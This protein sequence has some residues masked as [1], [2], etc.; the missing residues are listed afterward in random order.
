MSELMLIEKKDRVGIITFNSPQNKN[1]IGSG[2]MVELAEA[3]RTVINDPEVKVIVMKGAGHCFCAGGDTKAMGGEITADFLRASMTPFAD[4]TNLMINT[5][6]PI[7]AM[8]EGYAVGG[9]MA[10]ALHADFIVMSDT[11]KMML[12]VMKVGLVPEMGVFAHL[13][14]AVGPYT[15]K[16]IAFTN[17]RLSAEDCLN[18]GL[19]TMACSP[20]EIEEK[21]MALALELAEMPAVTMGI[22]KRAFNYVAFDKLPALLLCEAQHAPFLNL[23][24]EVKDY[25]MAYVAKLHSK[26]K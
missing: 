6:K 4:V 16:K 10:L 19:I 1:A 2:F 25:M 7:I 9:G 12:Q 5:E 8:V 17:P 13:T 20:E 14:Y 22:A 24:G 21:T 18:Y 23:S 26:K 3:L 15:A 11:A